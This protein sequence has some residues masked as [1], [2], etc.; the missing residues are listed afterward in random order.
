MWHGEQFPIPNPNFP[1]QIWGAARAAQLKGARYENADKSMI[2]SWLF[3]KKKIHHGYALR[4]IPEASK[5]PTNQ[6]KTTTS[7]PLGDVRARSEEDV[8]RAQRVK[9]AN[10]IAIGAIRELYKSVK[11]LHLAQERSWQ[12]KIGYTVLPLPKY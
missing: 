1:S 12:R 8:K 9:G 3:G 7:T 11:L 2:L 6:P 10:K 4:W 5:Q